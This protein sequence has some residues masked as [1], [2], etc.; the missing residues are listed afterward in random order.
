MTKIINMKPTIKPK[1]VSKADKEKA[2]AFDKAKENFA[3]IFTDN[4]VSYAALSSFVVNTIRCMPEDERL[5]TIRYLL[6]EVT[7]L[8]TIDMYEFFGM[9][10]VV[11]MDYLA[12]NVKC[13]VQREMEENNED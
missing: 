9:L 12:E 4:G 8:N 13:P 7:V 6:T 3:K 2:I 10:E 5:D 11:K 1:P